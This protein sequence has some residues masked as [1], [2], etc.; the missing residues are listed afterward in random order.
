MKKTF[1]IILSMVLT[2]CLLGCAKK[3]EEN[4]GFI[5]YE[6]TASADETDGG[7]HL[8]ETDIWSKEN[9]NA[10]LDSSIQESKTIVFDGQPYQGT[11]WYSVTEMFNNYQSDYYTFDGGWFAVK[12]ST[13]ALVSFVDCDVVEGNL[14]IEDC[15]D[16]AFRIANQVIDV[17]QYELTAT[18]DGLINT[19]FFQKYIDGCKTCAKLAVG[20]STS[21]KIVSFGYAM[22]DEID[23]VVGNKTALLENTI[24]NLNSVNGIGAIEEKVRRI[25]PNLHDYEIE[26]RTLVVAENGRVGVVYRVDV[27]IQDKSSLD[28]I[29]MV[30]SCVYI[31]LQE[32]GGGS[33]EE[34]S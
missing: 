13:G 28:E 31:L 23:L 17:E 19:Y 14:T 3:A 2:V 34:V 6:I 9:C 20:I 5:A 1:V 32:S 25:Y 4:N 22:I 7:L 8:N 10:S 27:E 16:E 26:D 12:S 33:G 18:S 30:S 21:G 11:Y 29:N 24:E 15:K